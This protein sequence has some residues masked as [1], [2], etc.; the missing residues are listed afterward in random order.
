MSQD[1]RARFKQMCSAGGQPLGG[2]APLRSPSLRSG[3]LR[4]ARPPT[5]A[6]EK[7]EI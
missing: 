3:S 5:A 4:C 2:R 7:R 1:G 6:G